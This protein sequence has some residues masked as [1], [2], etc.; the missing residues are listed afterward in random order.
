M[1]KYPFNNQLSRLYNKFVA[2]SNCSAIDLHQK[3]TAEHPECRSGTMIYW[4]VVEP[5]LWKIWVRQ[6]EGWHPIYEMENKNCSK[7]PTSIFPR[8][9]AASWIQPRDLHDACARVAELCDS[10]WHLE[11]RWKA[12]PRCPSLK[13][14]TLRSL[15]MGVWKTKITKIAVE[16]PQLM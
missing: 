16:N 7:P 10:S 13:R 15:K 4:L 3:H 12:L 1:I 11:S 9:S 5:P 6:W 14:F 2:G 8:L